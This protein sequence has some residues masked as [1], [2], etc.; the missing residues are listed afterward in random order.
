LLPVAR[1]AA[2][3]GRIQERTMAMKILDADPSNW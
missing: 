1:D 3:A 2:R